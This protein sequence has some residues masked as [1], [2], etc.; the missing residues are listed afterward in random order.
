MVNGNFEYLKEIICSVRHTAGHITVSRS[1]IIMKYVE[2]SYF[3][4]WLS[5]H[6]IGKHPQYNSPDCH[7]L[8]MNNYGRYWRY[9]KNSDEYYS[10]LKFTIN[11]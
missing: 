3:L 11:H 2:E 10:F 7:F 5:G 8:P 6:S 4:K 1:D 9:P